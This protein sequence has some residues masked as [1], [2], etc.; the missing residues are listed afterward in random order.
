MQF[1]FECGL[2]S[3]VESAIGSSVGSVF[4]LLCLSLL[5]SESFVESVFYIDLFS[6]CVFLFLIYNLCPCLWTLEEFF[7][8]ILNAVLILQTTS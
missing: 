8:A 6:E 2:D 5:F 4:R 1:K 3:S 7:S